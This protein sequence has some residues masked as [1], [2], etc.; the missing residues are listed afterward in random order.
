MTK[1]I[2]MNK[3]NIV[4][5]AYLLIALFFAIGLI[6]IFLVFPTQ[7]GFYYAIANNQIVEALHLSELITYV[8]LSIPC[9]VFLVIGIKIARIIIAS[10]I[11]SNNIIFLIRCA[12]IL[13]LLDSAMFALTNILFSIISCVFSYEVLYILLG[14]VGASI[15]VVLIV[16]AHYWEAAIELKKENEE[17]I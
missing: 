1:G 10:D 6:M 4:T 15:G 17:F 11:F 9:F 5:V 7:T 16:V 12:G 2:N 13:L 3:K 8:L 14:I